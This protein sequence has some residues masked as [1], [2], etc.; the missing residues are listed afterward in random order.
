MINLKNPYNLLLILGIV[1]ATSYLAPKL[2]QTFKSEDEYDLI[3]KYLLNDS[4]LYGYNKPKLW[5]HTKYET[6]ARKWKSFNSRNSTDLNQPY[7]HLT[8]KSI[9][10]HCGNDFNVC[11]IDDDTFSKLIP[12]WDMNIQTVAEPLKSHYREI[13]LMNLL[14]FYGGMIVPNSFICMKN[15][16][17][18][19]DYGTSE[20]KPFVC[21]NA[22]KTLNQF[23]DKYKTSF[24][25]DTFFM[26]APKNCASIQDYIEFLKLINANGHFSSE[27]DFLGINSHWCTDEIEK[28]NMNLI[29]GELIGIKTKKGRTIRIENLMEE[30]YL[31]LN[32]NTYGIYIPADEVKRRVKYQWFAVLSSEDIFESD[33]IIVKYLKLSI[34]NTQSEYTK[35]SVI[36]SVVAL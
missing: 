4:P 5:I 18:L 17:G 24:V 6:N 19:Y 7:I 2:K 26:G 30:Q 13:G 22:N 8:I 11:L 21:E 10:N 28:Q 25:P 1:V 15:L 16:K 20:N 33:P 3:K 31:D 12:N 32:S 14:Y 35:S 36:P 34:V 23:K 29:N 27:N 9:I